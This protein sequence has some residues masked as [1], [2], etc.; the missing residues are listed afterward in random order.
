MCN[1]LSF[2]WTGTYAKTFDYRVALAAC[3]EI[4]GAD[5][6]QPMDARRF[7]IGVILAS[8]TVVPVLAAGGADG[9]Y[10]FSL[11]KMLAGEGDVPGALQA[12]DQ[13]VGAEPDDPYLRVEYAEFLFRLRRADRALEQAEAAYRLAPESLDVLRMYGQVQLARASSDPAALAVAQQVFEKL[14]QRAP[15]DISS[16]LA[17]GQIYASLERYGDA[18]DVYEELVGYHPDNP[19]LSQ[20]LVETL[21]RAGREERAEEV[22]REVLRIDGEA[23]E[24]R[25]RLAGLESEKGN[26]SAAIDILEQAGPEISGD[27]RL[28]SML[29]HELYRRALS[30]G[31]SAEQREADLAEALTLVRET[32]AERPDA[33]ALVLLEAD[34]LVEEER[35]DE[36]VDLLQE[37]H[38][39]N[40][41]DVSVTL[42]LVQALER[43]GDVDE[44]VALLRQLSE[45]L[46]DGEALTEIRLRLA[47]M[48]ARHGDWA[49][50]AKVTGQ[51]LDGGVAEDSDLHG[52]VLSLHL[53]ALLRLERYDEA[54]A[55]L[56]REEKRWGASTEL[57]LQ[58]AQIFVEAGRRKDALALLEREE[59]RTAEDLE[60]RVERARLLLALDESA[61]AAAAFEEIADD[62]H[63]ETLILAG[64]A[65][66]FEERWTEA[67]PFLQR[68]LDSDSLEEQ[69]Q[70]E[71]R[72]SIGMAEERSGAYD[73][74]ADQ[75]RRVIDLEPE[76]SGAMNYLGYM[77]AEQGTHLDEALQLIEKAVALQPE[78]GAY[79]DSLGWVLFKLGRH[80]EAQVQLQR[81][82][83]LLPDDPTIFEHLGDVYVALGDIR[84]ARAAYERALQINSEENVEQVRRKLSEL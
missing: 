8:S 42:Q 78:N 61:E 74:A 26:H 1:L 35:F 45:S 6:F 27:P 70:V 7:L 75:F 11:A 79:V 5:T 71:V 16:M 60:V 38:E 77:W 73:E 83:D 32:L 55:R 76:H 39:D 62:Q 28:R 47:G 72:Y 50:V 66:L 12:F 48:H 81:A 17:L 10:Y 68:A 22:L 34:I 67:I 25:L 37:L 69:T 63:P 14:R 40:P 30:P 41:A 43:H 3:K 24:S 29:A 65:Y 21:T 36:A 58:R 49:S 18:A 53:N 84:Q 9:P 15:D 20:L 52:Q 56:R 46:Q 4:V 64:Q 2:T 31:I 13:A 44:A 80:A 23:L 59:L 82:A 33:G 54:L 19:R 57:L 51:L